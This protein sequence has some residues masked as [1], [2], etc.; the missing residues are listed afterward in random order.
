MELT[1][2]RAPVRTPSNSKAS[3]SIWKKKLEY[4]FLLHTNYATRMVHYSEKMVSTFTQY[5]RL[6]DILIFLLLSPFRIVTP[7]P[8]QYIPTT[9]ISIIAIEGD[10]KLCKG[11]AL[12]FSFQK[13][14]S[15]FGCDVYYPLAIYLCIL[16]HVVCS[17]AFM[18]N[19]AY[20]KI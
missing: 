19:I 2:H 1:N 12:I 15:V 9:I 11:I 8:T 3:W 17:A 13:F 6:W 14:Y 4:L 18:V 7:K 16:Y 20:H 10:A 5:K